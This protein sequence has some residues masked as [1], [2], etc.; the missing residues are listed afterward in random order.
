M[1]E[2][3]VIVRLSKQGEPAQIEEVRATQGLAELLA[4]TARINDFA[5]RIKGYNRQ[6]FEI[7]FKSLLLTFLIS[8]D[9][10]SQWFRPY[11]DAKEA[12]GVPV[13]LE[14]RLLDRKDLDSIGSQLSEID[15]S[16]LEEVRRQTQDGKLLVDAARELCK[17]TP[18]QDVERP[19]D[20]RHLIGAYIYSPPDRAESS[21]R[22]NLKSWGYDRLRWSNAFLAQI[23]KLNSTELEFWNDI[24]VRTFSIPAEI[25]QTQGPS[26]HI[27]TDLWTTDDELGYGAYAYALSKF[28]MHKQSEPPLTISIQA[29]WGGGKTSLMRMIQKYLDP[30]AV[31]KPRT[32]EQ[33][34]EATQPYG[35]VS[36]GKALGEAEKFIQNPQNE[37]PSVPPDDQRKLFTVWFNAWKYENTREVWAG[38]ANEIMQQVAAQLHPQDRELFWLRLN[39]RRI[40]ADRIRQRIYER[41]FTYWWRGIWKWGVP[42]IVVLLL[43]VIFALAGLLTGG[44]ILQY[45]GWS[46]ASLSALASVVVA[47]LKFLSANTSVRQEPAAVSLNDLL[48]VPDYNAE[49]GFIHS[50]AAD[51]NRVLDSVPEEG[52]IV[53]FIDDLDRCSPAKVAQVVEAV[54]LFL[55]G[56]FPNCLFV[57]GMD[58]E[59]VAA[60]LQAAH[61]DMIACLPADA[62]IPVGWRFMDKFVQLPFIIPPAEKPQMR[63]YT[64][65]L[66]SAKNGQLDDPRL[67]QEVD[68][69]KEQ[70]NTREDMHK[71][72]ERMEQQ[73][74]LNDIQITRVTEVL[75]SQVERQDF[76]KR[77]ESYSDDNSEIRERV[78]SAASY[79]QGNPR[80]IKRFINAFRLQFFLWSAHQSRGLPS[81]TLDQL[82]RWTV[83]SMKWPEVVRWLRRGGESEWGAVV[84]DEPLSDG[85]TPPISTRLKLIEK[86]SRQATNLSTWQQNAKDDLRLTPRM[87]PWLNDDE[88]LKFFHEEATREEGQRL[89]DG[90]GKGLW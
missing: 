25:P 85:M 45:V 16:E 3:V 11:V 2:V 10:W 23:A 61:K 42:L 8:D 28:M 6:G 78:I 70:V 69:A 74:N 13:L 84:P 81:P 54:N 77:I 75:E 30:E 53:I 76:D 64:L 32:Q 33:G 82:Q 41:I 19:L 34:E 67:E 88:L 1:D 62:G 14:S 58:A 56:E 20:V 47:I 63:R 44:K 79:F 15:P 12:S 36:V 48:D 26:T 65:S 90:A 46:G 22:L 71:Q 87:A 24:H 86:A 49:L 5:R 31:P 66:F 29:S 68:Q 43:S 72:I 55:G 18:P 40:D 4:C 80:E 89:S 57:M 83:L 59:M 35:A 37:L 38:L 52:P 60:A 21:E 9:T 39:L 51:L 50:V 27:A 7:S 17:E 73:G